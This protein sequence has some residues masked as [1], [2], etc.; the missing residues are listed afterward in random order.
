MRRSRRSAVRMSTLWAV[1]A[2]WLAGLPAFSAPEPAKKAKK[3]LQSMTDIKPFALEYQL[4][5]KLSTMPGAKREQLAERAAYLKEFG[6]QGY[7]L[8][9][10]PD[11]PAAS[12]VIAKESAQ[13]KRAYLALTDPVLRAASASVRDYATREHIPIKSGRAAD[14]S[15]EQRSYPIHALIGGIGAAIKEQEEVLLGLRPRVGSF[16]EQRAREEGRARVQRRIADMK[17]LQSTL[18]AQAQSVDI[19]APLLGEIS[20]AKD[21]DAVAARRAQLAPLLAAAAAPGGE[22]SKAEAFGTRQARLTVSTSLRD[23]IRSTLAARVAA[24]PANQGKKV[25]FVSGTLDFL[26]RVWP[27]SA[28]GLVAGDYRITDYVCEEEV[29]LTVFNTAGVSRR[30][31]VLE[32]DRGLSVM[33]ET[34]SVPSLPEKKGAG[35]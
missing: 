19:Y 22:V 27:W 17:K 14:V 32:H 26:P 25:R 12:E 33:L 31:V 2:L 28:R 7:A 6:G 29:I 15:P 30:I 10:L 5:A 34:E 9:A 11:L 8:R 21:K 3:V 18:A 20:R 35:K 1:S 4:L 24:D 23:M 13:I 16:E